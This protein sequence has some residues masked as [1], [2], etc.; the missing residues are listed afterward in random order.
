MNIY[1]LLVTMTTNMRVTLTVTTQMRKY[2]EIE[3]V[4]LIL[5]H[6]LY[7]FFSCAV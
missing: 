2:S 1:R 4:N 7:K 6:D 5:P 3:L